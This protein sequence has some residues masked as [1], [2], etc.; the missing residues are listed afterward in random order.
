MMKES[1][2]KNLNE[3]RIFISGIA[4]TSEETASVKALRDKNAWHAVLQKFTQH[5][6]ST[7]L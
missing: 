1:S 5:C 3:L 6:K 7:V 2:I 4:N